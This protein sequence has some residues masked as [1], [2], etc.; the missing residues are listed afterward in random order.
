MF[1][2][3]AAA[4]GTG[5]GQ[6]RG[7]RLAGWLCLAAGLLGAAS[8]VALLAVPKSVPEDRFSYP[9]EA[10]PFIAIQVWFVV[11]HLGLLVGQQGLWRAGALGDGRW[12]LVGHQLAFWGMALLTMTE[13]VATGAAE[14][15]YP[16]GRTD[17][18]DALYGVA[19]TAVGLGLTIAGAVGARRGAYSDWRRWVPLTIG[20]YVW[21]P[22]FP[23]LVSGFVGARL[24]ITGW[25]LLYAVAG[26]ALLRGPDRPR[27]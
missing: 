24:G 7:V 2:S 3:M 27:S 14:S 13:L 23:A 20:V 22:M 16:S 17:I 11:Q 25:M 21:V 5:S 4:L 10:G 1:T 18:L 8:G 6:G 12:A 15:I 19:T 9:L 26:W